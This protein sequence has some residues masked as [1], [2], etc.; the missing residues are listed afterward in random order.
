MKKRERSDESDIS[1]SDNIGAALHDYKGF[2]HL[3]C[4]LWQRIMP[5]LLKAGATP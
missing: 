3:P 5:Q 4:P 2:V 1:D